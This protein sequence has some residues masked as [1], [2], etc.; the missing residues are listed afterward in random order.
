MFF[1]VAEAKT[2]HRTLVLVV[3]LMTYAGLV[4]VLLFYD[5]MTRRALLK[6]RRLARE[7]NADQGTNLGKSKK[8]AVKWELPHTSKVV[9]FGV[10][11]GPTNT[12]TGTPTTSTPMTGTPTTVPPTTGTPTTVTP[13]NTATSMAALQPATTSNKA[14]KV[15]PTTGPGKK[16]RL[17]RLLK[18]A[19]TTD[20]PLGERKEKGKKKKK[21]KT[22]PVKYG[23]FLQVP[24]AKKKKKEKE[25]NE[26]LHDIVLH[27][28]QFKPMPPK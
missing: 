1:T 8:K 19:A 17:Y 14:K 16:G 7:T 27:V 25:K 18:Y 23:N 22:K 15:Q 4:I 3:I 21:K 28:P 12:T 20:K 13:N 26:S 9:N 6:Y 10:P 11:K 5:V 24:G 2:L